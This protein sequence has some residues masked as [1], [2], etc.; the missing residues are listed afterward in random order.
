[1]NQ[2]MLSEDHVGTASCFLVASDEEF[3]GGDYLQAS[4]KLWGAASHAALAL[5][6]KRGSRNNRPKAIR[7]MI[8][9]VAES[10][11]APFLRAAYGVAEKFHANFYHNFLPPDEEFAESREVVHQ[12]V[13]AV[14]ELVNGESQSQNGQ[15]SG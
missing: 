8:R 13:A 3:Q 1:M 7:M 15:E 11:G 5:A 14:L 2:P 12:F 9:E 10:E 4:E 6:K